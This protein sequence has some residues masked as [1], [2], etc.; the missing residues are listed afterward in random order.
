MEGPCS[1]CAC[2][3]PTHSFELL[4][5]P[6]YENQRVYS[7]CRK[8]GQ[9]YAFVMPDYVMDRPIRPPTMLKMHMEG[10]VIVVDHWKDA[11]GEVGG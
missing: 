3:E 6:D 8:C 1:A 9:K 2:G 11:Q 5:P 4:L 7:K 10:D